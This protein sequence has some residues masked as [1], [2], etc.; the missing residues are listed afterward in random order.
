[1]KISDAQEIFIRNNLN[2]VL[3]TR[4]AVK[5]HKDSKHSEGKYPCDLCDR[6]LATADGLRN[7]IKYVH[8]KAKAWNNAWTAV[9]INQCVGNVLDS[10]KNSTNPVQEF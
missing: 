7:H 5:H 10:K 8:T 6:K 2:I 1:M 4:D 3:G 9:L